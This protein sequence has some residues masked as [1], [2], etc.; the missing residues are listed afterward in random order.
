MKLVIKPFRSLPCELEVFTINGKAANYRDF[1]SVF[2]HNEKARKPY[3][4]GDMQFEPKLPITEVL[5]RYNITVDE[6]NIIC[7]ELE[8]KLNIGK[9]GWCI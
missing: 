1:G 4:C 5:E 8:N 3:G 2:D 6:Y 9:C 7:T